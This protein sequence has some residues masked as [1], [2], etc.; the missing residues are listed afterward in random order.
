MQERLRNLYIF[1]KSVFALFLVS[2]LFVS[3][4]CCCAQILHIANV[5]G[6]LWVDKDSLVA[7]RNKDR[8]QI[9]SQQRISA[10]LLSQIAFKTSV[11]QWK[12]WEINLTASGA[13]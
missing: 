1:L 7:D 9:K 12:Y 13:E 8:K 3:V 11:L 6:L 10:L 4:W 2:F 5:L